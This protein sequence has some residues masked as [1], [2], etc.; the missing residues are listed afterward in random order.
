MAFST[1]NTDHLTRSELWSSQLKDIL[2]DELYAQRYIRW[3]NEFG[4]GDLIHIPSI[5]QLEA[6]D[7]VEGQAVQYSSMDT[8]DFTFQITEYK[9]T[10]TYITNKAKQDFYYAQELVSSF[11]PKQSRALMK[12]M[13]VDALRVGPEGQTASDPNRINGAV[14]RWVGTGTGNTISVE[15][16]ARARHSLQV[17]NVPMSNLV[18][19]VDPSVEFTFNTLSNF[20]NMSFNP[21]WEGI[22][23]DGI[24]TGMQFKVNIYGFDVYV[25]HNLKQGHTETILGQA[26]TDGVANLFFSATPDLLPIVGAV[27]QAPKVDSEYNKDLQREEYVT[28]CRYGMKLFRP[29]NLVVVLTDNTVADPSYS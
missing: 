2:E 1:S 13:E 9:Q 6:R 11:L 21:A 29:E 5:G 17:A 15:D 3:L 28:T 20:T 22:V 8:G 23:R 14:H 19:I 12:E 4:D 25:S 16:F 18:A 27:R 10:G 26:A 7:Y 24:G